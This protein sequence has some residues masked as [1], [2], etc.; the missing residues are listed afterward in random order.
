MSLDSRAVAVMEC[1]LKRQAIEFPGSRGICGGPHAR[2]ECQGIRLHAGL[3][4]RGDISPYREARDNTE[5]G[6]TNSDTGA[7]TIPDC[8]RI[9]AA[10]QD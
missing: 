5:I 3:R 4:I 10:R 8:R 1:V 6:P 9:L 7:L 2:R